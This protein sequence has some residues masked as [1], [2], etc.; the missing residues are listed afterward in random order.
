MSNRLTDEDFQ[1]FQNSTKRLNKF[2]Q[3]TTEQFLRSVRS[4]AIP[5]NERSSTYSVPK[6]V[7]DNRYNGNNNLATEEQINK[8]TPPPTYTLFTDEEQKLYASGNLDDQIK[9]LDS[10][11]KRAD[12]YLQDYKKWTFDDVVKR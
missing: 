8:P 4:F 3:N 10:S 11:N 12:K 7:N 1:N 2:F 5:W 6:N 9:A